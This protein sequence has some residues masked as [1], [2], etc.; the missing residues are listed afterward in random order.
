ME[1]NRACI[2]L[3]PGE[4]VRSAPGREGRFV[5]PKWNAYPVSGAAGEAVA[6]ELSMSGGQHGFEP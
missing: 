3:D 2:E 5:S 1:R 6:R 4:R